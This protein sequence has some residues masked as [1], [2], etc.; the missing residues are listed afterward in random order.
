MTISIKEWGRDHVSTLL[1]VENRCV[2]QGGKPAIEHMRCDPARHPGLAHRGSEG[3]PSPTRLAQGV[4]ENHDDWDCIDDFEAWGLLRNTGTGIHP[5]W[6]LTELGWAVAH[7]LRR[8]R[9]EG[10]KVT[11]LCTILRDLASRG[12]DK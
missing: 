9:A 11:D 4:L 5:V 7:A 1:Y 2:D 8:A 6:K 3:K 12:T 10:T